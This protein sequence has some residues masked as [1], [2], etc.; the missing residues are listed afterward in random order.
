MASVTRKPARTFANILANILKAVVEI[1]FV[2][3]VVSLIY[4]YIIEKAVMPK[5]LT[6]VVK[7]LVRVDNRNESSNMIVRAVTLRA[8]LTNN[9]ELRQLCTTEVTS[10]I[11]TQRFEKR[12][13]VLMVEARQITEVLIL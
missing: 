12:R 8:V 13:D 3:L 5:A 6:K 10:E 11:L 7:L 1:T 2:Q 9:E 4:A